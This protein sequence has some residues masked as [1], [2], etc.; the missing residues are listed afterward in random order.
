MDKN[1]NPTGVLVIAAMTSFMSSFTASSMNIALPSIDKELGM[2]A[3]LLSWVSTAF[4][5][6]SAAF[7]IFF[8]KAADIYGRK[9]VF[10]SGIIVYILSSIL[11]LFSYTPVLL[12]A[13][14][15]F[16]GVGGAM[17]FSTSA[18]ILMSVIPVNRRGR[19]IGI[20]TAAVYVGLSAGPFIGGLITH[21]L[22]W[23]SIFIV[24]ISLG[25]IILPLIALFMKS[26]W[27]EAEGEKL[28]WLGSFIYGISLTAIIFGFSLVP[29]VSGFIITLLGIA[30]IFLFVNWEKRAASPVL[31]VKLFLQNRSFTFSNLAAMINYSATFSVTFFLSLYLQYIKKL[32]PQAA[33]LI[34]LSQPI[35]QAVFSPLT[36]RM[37]DKIEPRV[38]SSIGMAVTA[39]GLFLL[40]FFGHSTPEY[41]VVICLVLLGF[42]F[43][44]F[45]SPNTNAVM[46]SVEKKYY[47]VASA[48]L[49]TMRLVGQMLSMGI[50]MLLFALIIGRVKISVAY[51]DSLLKAMKAGFVLFSVLCAAGIFASLARGNMRNKKQ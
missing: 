18:A 35:V 51:A 38:L 24:N 46:S 42:G 7:L 6:S 43:A 10:L 15:A 50:A 21:Y 23:R 28:D 33:G 13:S 30:G 48:M 14:R 31:D 4:L 45:S 22:G 1:V 19:A 11:S 9:K 8:G 36:G 12:I 49:G 44:L 32:T 37:S 26:E 17:I 34:L 5:L 41:Y 29:D 2:N 47:G 20:N 16:Q 40:T 39:A 27:A 25:L 3:V